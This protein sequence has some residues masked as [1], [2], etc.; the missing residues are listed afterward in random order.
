MREGT[1]GWP[2]DALI[3]HAAGE[4]ERCMRGVFD[5]ARCNQPSVMCFSKF[6][7]LFGSSDEAQAARRLLLR[8]MDSLAATDAVVFVVG[9]TEQ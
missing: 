4:L 7:A 9:A 6:E 5:E 2:S 3:L 8:H 1:L